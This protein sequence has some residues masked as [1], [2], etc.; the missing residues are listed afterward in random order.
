M[1]SRAVGPAPVVVISPDERWLSVLEITLRLGGFQPIA[2]RSIRDALHLRAGEHRP[3]AVVLDLGADSEPGDIEAVRELL[4]DADVRMVVI[5]P[6]RLAADRSR[7]EQDGV[8]ILVRPYPPSDLYRALGADPGPDP[9]GPEPGPAGP[10][11]ADDPAGGD[12]GP[13]PG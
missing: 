3:S 4:A 5:L 11:P 13:Q 1:Y 10:D 7:I 2:R 9:S 12:V 6:E 8:T